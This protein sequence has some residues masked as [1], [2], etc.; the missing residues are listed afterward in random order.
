[1]FT[2]EQINDLHA[3]LGNAKTFPDYVRALK[4]LG[5][6]RYDSYL[7]DG[8]SEYEGQGGHRVVLPPCTRCFPWLKLSFSPGCNHDY[9]TERDDDGVVHRIA[10]SGNAST[11]AP[12]L[13]WR[14]A[15]TT[16]TDRNVL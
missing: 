4:T 13:L 8:H 3:R 12:S 5:V 1:M 2:I 11:V 15:W 10:T 16:S 14:R 9:R 7:A 6:E